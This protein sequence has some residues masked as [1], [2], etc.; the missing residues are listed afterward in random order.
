MLTCS[1][2]DYGR[3]V[4]SGV[5]FYVGPVRGSGFLFLIILVVVL[6]WNVVQLSGDSGLEAF[7]SWLSLL[8]LLTVFTFVATK[9]NKFS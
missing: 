2:D 9:I 7:W 8:Y 3:S 1:L 4:S 6:Y 5:S